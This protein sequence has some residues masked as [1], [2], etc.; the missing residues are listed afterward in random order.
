MRRSSAPRRPPRGL[1]SRKARG[2]STTFP[3]SGAGDAGMQDQN[4]FAG[5]KGVFMLK[6]LSFLSLPILLA[7]AACSSATPANLVDARAAYQ[8]ASRGSAAQLA[9]AQL[10]VAQTSLDA[11]E[12]TYE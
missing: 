7:A 2:A 4:H 10:H 6:E 9:P 3:V 8:R 5:P 12:R 1:Q 11:A